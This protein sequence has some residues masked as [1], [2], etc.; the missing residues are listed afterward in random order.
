M[1]TAIIV[2]EHLNGYH[3]LIE[4]AIFKSKTDLVP[5]VMHTTVIASCADRQTVLGKRRHPM[6]TAIIAEEHLNGY[7]ARTY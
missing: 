6:A 1:P 3:K 7:H 2:D 4:M 5:T